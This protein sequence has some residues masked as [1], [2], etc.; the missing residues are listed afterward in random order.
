M[1]DRGPYYR[2][3]DKNPIDRIEDK[4]IKQWYLD[5]FYPIANFNKLVLDAE[6]KG[7]KLNPKSGL[8]LRFSDEEIEKLGYTKIDIIF[9]RPVDLHY[10]TDVDGTIYIMK[11]NVTFCIGEEG[12]TNSA[13]GTIKTLKPGKKITI[14]KNTLHTFTPQQNQGLE[15]RLECSGILDLKKEFCV[16][17]FDSYWK[18]Y[19]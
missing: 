8:L 17:S 1:E 7:F 16:E 2:T 6:K 13:F 11:G 14:K 4:K 3:K 12:D 18:G 9:P 19:Y 15:I 10:H 5:N